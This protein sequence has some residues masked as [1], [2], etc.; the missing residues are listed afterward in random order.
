MR[1]SSQVFDLIRTNL[2][3]PPNSMLTH[4]EKRCLLASRTRQ[5]AALRL[6]KLEEYRATLRKTVLELRTKNLKLKQRLAIFHT[7]AIKQ[8]NGIVLSL[9]ADYMHDASLNTRV[10]DE[11]LA[12]FTDAFTDAEV[13]R[14]DC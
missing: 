4:K 14:S 6:A 11:I 8:Q 9:E 1:N 10:W 12:A 13:Q 3:F 7:E 5:R 2:T